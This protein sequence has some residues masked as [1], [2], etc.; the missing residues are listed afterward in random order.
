MPA[1]TSTSMPTT[2]MQLLKIE[3]TLFILFKSTQKHHD[4]A[5]YNVG[6]SVTQ[7]KINGSKG[8]KILE[9]LQKRYLAHI[10]TFGTYTKYSV[11]IHFGFH[12]NQGHYAYASCIAF[13]KFICG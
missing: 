6:E 12:I 13:F 10:Q 7:R 8:E 1:S 9:H 3:L 11:H 2:A 4:N 5:T